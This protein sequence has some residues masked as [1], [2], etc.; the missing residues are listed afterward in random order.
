MVVNS[1]LLLSRVMFLEGEENVEGF[2]MKLLLS[3]KRMLM[4]LLLVTNCFKAVLI[5]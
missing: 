2:N 3:R 1:K 5:N 4:L